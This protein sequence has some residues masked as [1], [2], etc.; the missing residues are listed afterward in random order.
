MAALATGV[1]YGLSSRS[2]NDNISLFFVKLTD[3]SYR[4]IEEY[5][6]SVDRT[7]QAPT[8]QFLKNKGHLSIQPALSSRLEVFSFNISPN[9]DEG[10]IVECLQ[11]TGSRALESLGV[12]SHTI[13]IQAKEDSY[14]TTKHRMA[15][16]EEQQKKNRTKVIKPTV[17]EIGRTVKK[18]PGSTTNATSH[19]LKNTYT[20]SSRGPMHNPPLQQH[21][22]VVSNNH[23]QKPGNPELMRRPLRERLIHVLALKPFKKPEILDR[24]RKEGLLQKDINNVTKMLNEVAKNKGNT[25][26]L[27]RGFW[28]DVQEDWP[29]YT[30][31]DRQILKRR[32]PQ[33]LTPPGSSDTGSTGSGQSPTSTHP[34]SPPSIIQ[35]P[36]KRASES[37]DSVVPTKKRISH[38]Q[39]PPNDSYRS[40]TDSYMTVLHHQD[41]DDEAPRLN[42]RLYGDN[43]ALDDRRDK[44]IAN[45]VNSKD[46]NRKDIERTFTTVK[47]VSDSIKKSNIV[48]SDVSNKRPNSYNNVTD[49]SDCKRFKNSSNSGERIYE[50]KPDEKTYEKRLEES[51]KRSDSPATVTSS[52]PQTGPKYDVNYADTRPSYEDT[53]DKIQENTV[54]ASSELP[55]YITEYTTILDS[56]QRKKY[57]DDFLKDYE[58]YKRLHAQME[59]VTNEFSQLEAEMKRA[60]NPREIQRLKDVIKALSKQW[61]ED[62]K[63]QD[64][65]KRFNYLHA[66]LQHIK[67][68]VAEYDR[69]ADY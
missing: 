15:A 38:F 68:L 59:R 47:N 33:N 5:A 42:N 41:L 10:N 63:Y 26:E 13:N 61:N 67:D 50:R 66:K 62:Q 16:V 29:F 53:D 51:I 43:F 65:K 54:S 21:S 44:R 45:S 11:S 36:L 24:L 18:V 57:K 35:N 19:I 39:R 6:K 40:V 27:V 58:E 52:Q 20:S 30:E 14:E 28:N 55:D 60:R 22:R 56:K 12:L 25:Y 32:K 17:N 31:Q 2:S 23:A 64:G 9:S 8:I 46:R 69:T 37:V 49:S 7:S 48:T 34:G 1:Q 4:A 3:S